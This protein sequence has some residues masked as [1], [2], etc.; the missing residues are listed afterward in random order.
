VVI[1]TIS[2]VSILLLR[3]DP[4]AQSLRERRAR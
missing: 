3:P 4:R 2:L 1:A